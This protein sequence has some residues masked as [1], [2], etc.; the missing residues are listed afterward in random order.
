MLNYPPFNTN[1]RYFWI[2]TGPSGTQGVCTDLAAV[3][4]FISIAKTSALYGIWCRVCTVSGTTI[5]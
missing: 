3:G 4:P 5:T 1:L 2:S